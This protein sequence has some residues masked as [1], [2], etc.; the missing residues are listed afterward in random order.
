MTV[1]VTVLVAAV[2]AEVLQ[3]LITEVP[4]ATPVTTTESAPEAG[5]VATSGLEL[6]K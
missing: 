1:K 3:T 2:H 6:T 4:T 5:T